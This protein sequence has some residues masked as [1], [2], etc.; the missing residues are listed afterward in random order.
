MFFK[1]DAM[2][3]VVQENFIVQRWVWD[4]PLRR[5]LFD[6]ELDQ[7]NDLIDYLG[8][9]RSS[10]FD[11][12]WNDQVFQGKEIDW[13]QLELLVRVRLATWFKAKFP[14]RD[15]SLENL[16]SDPLLASSLCIP[17]RNQMKFLKWS[18]PPSS[19]LKLNVNGD[20]S[21]FSSRGGIGG[22]LRD[23][24]G[25]VLFESSEGYGN[26]QVA[27]ME[28]LAMKTGIHKFLS[29][30]WASSHRLIIEPDCKV[31]NN[32]V[33]GSEEPPIYSRLVLELSDLIK[34]NGFLCRIVPPVCNVEADSLAKSGIGLC[35]VLW[36]SWF[37]VIMA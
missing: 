28:L 34:C 26:S 10:S 19:F 27:W 11:N 25:K 15:I 20:V 31:L 29:S 1:D 24:G 2:G 36:G 6:W 8:N 5:S 7:W 30:E 21:R 13:V 4:I 16:I 23:E 9:F 3:Q 17:V 18:P 32:W 33:L 12:D 14:G 35:G 37:I 22:L